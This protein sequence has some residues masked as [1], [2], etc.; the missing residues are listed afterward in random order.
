MHL[1]PNQDER[2]LSSLRQSGT[3]GSFPHVV[4]Q[5]L[6]ELLAAAA[7]SFADRVGEFGV[8]E[9]GV[10][11]VGGVHLQGGVGEPVQDE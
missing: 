10:V 3:A 7:E 4:F 2:H 6:V 1:T 8:R 5:A 9:V 11:E